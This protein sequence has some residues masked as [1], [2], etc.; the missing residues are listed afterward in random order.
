MQPHF[1]GDEVTVAELTPHHVVAAAGPFCW[2]CPEYFSQHPD[3]SEWN[4]LQ[5]G[6]ASAAPFPQQEGF[7]NP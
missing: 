7:I 5:T 1:T 2:V 3:C 4:L 6:K